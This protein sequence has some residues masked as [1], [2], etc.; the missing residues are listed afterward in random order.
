MKEETQKGLN[1]SPLCRFLGLDS[2]C[3]CYLHSTVALGGGVPETCAIF[4]D[5]WGCED[6]F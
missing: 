2:S 6:R 4:A 1:Q 3:A 5:L